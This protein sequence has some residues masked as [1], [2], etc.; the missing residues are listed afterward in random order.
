MM[1]KDDRR[2]LLL[3][4]T[5]LG[6][7]F[8]AVLAAMAWQNYTNYA[9]LESPKV[10]VPLSDLLER[11]FIENRHVTL[12]D[13][14]FSEGFAYETGAVGK[15]HWVSVSVPVFPNPA[16]NQKTIQAIVVSW[17]ISNEEQLQ[18]VLEQA[19]VSGILCTKPFAPGITRGPLLEEANPGRTVNKVWAL[20]VFRDPPKIET[21]RLTASGAIICLLAGCVCIATRRRDVAAETRP[22]HVDETK[23]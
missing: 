10:R 9:I 12:T 11:D 8:G 3:S 7:L 6:F 5:G 21:I 18:L 22:A 4:G 15:D 16:A 14:T 20:Q 19:E 23:V 1:S 13:F 17:D 2:T